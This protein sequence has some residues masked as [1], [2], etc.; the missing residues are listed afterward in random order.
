MTPS[1]YQQS[2]YDWVR[3]GSGSAVVI[4]VA[5]SGKTTTILEALKFIPPS[6]SVRLFAFN[7]A[8]SETLKSRIPWKHV[9]ASTYHSAGYRAIL[10]ELHAKIDTD[11]NKSRDLIRESLSET[12]RRAYGDELA[13][14]LSLAKG[15]GMGVLVED[16]LSVWRMLIEDHDL[17]FDYLI[18]PGRKTDEQFEQALQEEQTRVIGLARD[19]LA[20]SNRAAQEPFAWHIDFDDQ[21]YLPVLWDL[22][23]P[24]YDWVMVD[25]AQDTN[26]IQREF[27][28][29]SLK[30]GGRLL[31][32]GDP[33]QAIYQWRG[34]SH[35]AIDLIT[36]E[37]HACELPLSVCYRCGRSIVEKAQAIVE[38]I[39]PAPDALPG[40]VVDLAHRSTLL[41]L[42]LTSA[43]LCR[44]NAPLV[45]H[46]Y[47]LIREGIP[48][49][50]L[51]RD[52]GE[53]LKKLVYKLHPDSV[54][55][56]EQKLRDYS[57]RETTRYRKL[58]QEA[59]AQGVE[60]RVACLQ[61]IIDSRD[62][63][64][65]TVEGIIE[66]VERLFGDAV[67]GQLTLSTIHKAKG[68][69]WP[70][71]ALICS[72]LIPSKWAQGAAALRQ[73]E[74]LLYVA[75]T[76]AQE[77]LLIIDDKPEWLKKKEAREQDQSREDLE[78]F[79]QERRW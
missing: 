40:Q 61:T 51:G 44:N 70:T 62:E 43:I 65:R 59:R 41:S 25:E 67:Q 15:I 74:N 4:A 3:D 64:D 19:L 47:E 13:R 26:A 10:R 72:Y 27:V 54:D 32:V 66:A 18:P 6:Q 56:L 45:R 29:R 58:K 22:A 21:L 7:R 12:D 42:P 8:I 57:R 5:G 48:C 76:R 49:K 55:D 16:T 34:A 2:I 50:V 30:P 79:V 71:V 69:E 52:I 68:Q 35:D 23:L 60:D 39:E 14:L 38:Q 46:A 20:A 28:R 75:Y 9:D 33:R 63:E 53:G 73:E 77:R 11:R 1:L 37:F 78:E 31:A 24:Q 36:K 17:N